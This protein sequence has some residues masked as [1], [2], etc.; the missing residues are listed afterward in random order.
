LWVRS[1]ERSEAIKRDGYT[2][3]ECHRKQTKKKGQE[4]KVEVHH[5]KEI[6]WDEIIDMLQE[7]LL[8]DPALLKTLCVD[9]HKLITHGWK[10]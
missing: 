8:C 1:C 6:E 2:C 4:L 9:C 7:R 5:L 10:E 3:Q